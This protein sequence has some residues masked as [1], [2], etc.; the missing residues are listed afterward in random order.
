VII[1]EFDDNVTS[2]SRILANPPSPDISMPLPFPHALDS[3]Q[4]YFPNSKEEGDGARVSSTT[5]T[6][7]TPT[8]STSIHEQHHNDTEVDVTATLQPFT[9]A[10]TRPPIPPLPTLDLVLTDED[11]ATE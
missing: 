2:T 11:F 5:L 10:S 9:T 7:T 1:G 3:S 8:T 6:T 4:W